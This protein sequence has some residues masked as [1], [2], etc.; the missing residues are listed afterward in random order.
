MKAKEI[1]HIYIFWATYYNKIQQFP[2]FKKINKD[3][4]EDSKYKKITLRF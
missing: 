1:N 3:K 4:F 2:G